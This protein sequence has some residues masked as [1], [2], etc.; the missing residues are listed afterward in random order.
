MPAAAGMSSVMTALAQPNQ[1]PV[2][3]GALRMVQS[4]T[5][6]KDA[7]PAMPAMASRM[8]TW[9]M[10]SAR[11]VLELAAGHGASPPQRCWAAWRVMPSR[12]A[13]SAQL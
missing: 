3:G 2:P 12:A 11:S 10:V 6:V 5:W 4:W 7:A 13:I 8:R 9:T 1:D